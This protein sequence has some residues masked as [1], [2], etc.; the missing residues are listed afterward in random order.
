VPG[1][2]RAGR[3]PAV[4][5]VTFRLLPYEIRVT[6]DDEALER[7]IAYLVNHA[8]Q[9]GVVR[10]NAAYHVA[11]NGPYE[12]LQDGDP[13]GPARTADDVLYLLYQ[14]CYGRLLD[15]MTLGGWVALH[16]VLV[17]VGGGR[18]I[19]VGEKGAGKTT[20][21]LRLL[22]DG[23][24]VEGDEIVFVRDGIAVALPRPFHLKPGTARLVPELAPSLDA[25]PS[26]STSDGMRI[27]AFDP[28]L[29]GFDWHLRVGPVDGVVVLRRNHDG[30][31]HLD[32]LTALDAVRFLVDHAFP[33]TESRPQLLRAAASVAGHVT[34]HQLE[35]GPVEDSARALREIG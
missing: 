4:V 21:A 3:P 20:L 35:V 11:G 6:A 31:A 15:H 5:D 2:L 10:R 29:A 30:E 17:R 33:A 28:A 19:M 7:T 14:R 23:C 32:E 8:T 13:M 26:T 27:V 22:H 24:P 1:H 16:G 9:D 12:L 34:A 25:L 18:R